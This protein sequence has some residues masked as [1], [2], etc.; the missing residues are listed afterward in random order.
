[1]R[2][3][4]GLLLPVLFVVVPWLVILVDAL[5]LGFHFT[6]S[7]AML[8]VFAVGLMFLAAGANEA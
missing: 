4:P 6:L 3:Q 8:V 1:M 2:A 5:L 7:L